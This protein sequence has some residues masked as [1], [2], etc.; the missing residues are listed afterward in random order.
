VECQAF[1]R[2]GRQGR[3]GTCQI[4]CSIDEHFVSQTLD[5]VDVK[6]G[7]KKFSGCRSNWITLA[8]ILRVQA[9][10]R[11]RILFKLLQC[12][13]EYVKELVGERL[14]CD[15]AKAQLELMYAERVWCDFFDELD[16][17]M[18]DLPDELDV[19]SWKVVTFDEF[20]QGSVR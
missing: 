8:S 3:K 4:I 20:K 18:R 2:A 13:F 10:K 14:G 12:Y 9:V 6:A 15:R 11:D 1:G 5:I 16:Q 7:A 19:E 17:E